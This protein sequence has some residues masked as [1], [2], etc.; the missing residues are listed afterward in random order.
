[1]CV[2]VAAQDEEVDK[3]CEKCSA[4]SATHK[5]HHAVQRLPEVLVVH[6]KRFN[7]EPMEGGQYR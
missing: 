2:F 3:A 7:L 5:V 6:L 4:S 1:M